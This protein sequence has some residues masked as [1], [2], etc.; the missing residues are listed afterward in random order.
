[1]IREIVRIG[2]CRDDFVIAGSGPL[3]ARGW[4]DDPSDLDIVARGAA[5]SAATR[6]VPPADAPYSTV[7][8]VVLREGQIEIFDGWFP[9]RWHVD[10]LIDG[11]DLIQGF[12]FLRLDVV[13]WYKAHLNRERD[14]EHLA[15]MAAHRPGGTA[16]GHDGRPAPG[17]AGA[18]P[19][20]GAPRTGGPPPAPRA[21]ERERR[22][23]APVG[24]SAR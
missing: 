17:V 13:S 6:L 15:I 24:T 22:A 10:E 19:W 1:M 12:R 8:R 20:T 5:W 3:Y 2:L 23:D 4:I 21:P 16:G 9:E 7:Q 11:A 14:R 18:G